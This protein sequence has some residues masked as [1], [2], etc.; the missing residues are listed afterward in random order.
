MNEPSGRS[1]AKAFFTSGERPYAA[2]AQLTLR[3]N[4]P[5]FRNLAR[6]QRSDFVRMQCG[7]VF[8]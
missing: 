1:I 5:D 3:F 2:P 7:I 8:A 6:H 4:E